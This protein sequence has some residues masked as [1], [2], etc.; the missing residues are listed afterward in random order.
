MDGFFLY[1]VLIPASS[2][3]TGVGNGAM[4]THRL[5]CDMADRFA[6]IAPVTGMPAKGFSCA[7]GGSSS[8]SIM[9]LHGNRDEYY[10]ADGSE[11][12]GSWFY[13]PVDD[14]IDA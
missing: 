8:T 14:V 13:V 3:D 9:Q 2:P 4:L 5:G 7:P 10:P 1:T 6:A 11:S 12:E